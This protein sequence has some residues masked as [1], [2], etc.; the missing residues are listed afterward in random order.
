[1]TADRLVLEAGS[2]RLTV[3]ASDGGR[4]SSLIVDGQELLVT[5]GFGPISW[6][7]YPMV[8]FAGR[9][10]HGR[11][12]FLGQAVQMPI[13]MAPHAI[14]GTVF[15]RRWDVI[16]AEAMSID[17]GPDWPFAGRVTHRVAL[18]P[19]GLD[20]TLT[21]DADVPMPVSMG[22]HPWF[23]RHLTGTPERP[24]PASAPVELAFDAATMLVR[25]A[26]GLPTGA[27][28]APTP[29]PWDDCFTDLRRPPAVAWP[30][31]LRL[32]LSSDAAYWVVYDEPVEA[33]CVEPQTEPPD[34]VNLAAAG[35]RQPTTVE[36]GRP[37]S[38]TMRWRWNR[39]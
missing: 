2:A 30:E 27:T 4:F 17:L 5:E 35:G 6:G 36:P 11:F 3:S 25:D 34:F 28:V 33:V 14:H 23:R 19:D 16:G 9:I 10:R 1:M 12:T 32:E 24:T 39:L 26:D 13:N 21:L 18:T 22:W 7:C 37:N 20:A 38:T 8:P 29:R 31:R 15:D